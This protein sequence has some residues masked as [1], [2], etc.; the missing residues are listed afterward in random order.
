MV[1]TAAQSYPQ[2][3]FP[4]EFVNEM[5]VSSPTWEERSMRTTSGHGDDYSVPW[6]YCRWSLAAESLAL[7]GSEVLSFAS[8]LDHLPT[9]PKD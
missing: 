5:V 8:P 7:G 4:Y 1:R 2:S 6:A 9:R 3:Y